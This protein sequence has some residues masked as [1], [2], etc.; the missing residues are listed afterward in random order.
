[1]DLKYVIAKDKEKKRAEMSLYGAIGSEING[2]YFAQS[3]D[4][5]SKEYDEI[6]IHI[7]SEGGSVMQ[8]LSI[9][10]AIL[11]SSA[12]I[13]AHIDGVAASMAG[14]IPMA[15]DKVVM[16]DFA[17][18]MIH[19][20]FFVGNN[21]LS[22]KEK[23]MLDNFTD[24]LADLL[25]RRG[26]EKEKMTEF[27]AKETWLKANEALELKLID[28]IVKTGKSPK[29]Q[30]SIAAIAALATEISPLNKIK[31][32][33]LIASLFG[34]SATATEAEIIAKVKALQSERDRLQAK[35][36]EVQKL[37]DDLKKE[38]EDKVKTDVN[39][40]VDKAIASGHFAKEQKEAL[41]E[42]GLKSFETFKTMVD[43][44]QP[45]K[46]SL[47]TEIQAQ[48][49]S[50]TGSQL[51]GEVKDFLWYSQNDPQ[52]LIEMKAS[53]PDKYRKLEKEYQEKYC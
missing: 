39:A 29:I 12:K 17:R 48:G 7:N 16:N 10:N 47:S 14:V 3:I 22:A 27:M 23:R 41:V 6:T 11:N 51:A 30:D 28:E 8:G 31:N 13:I 33:E 2:H 52:S 53:E 43:G 4:Y 46:S 37:A 26:I 32:M 44:L 45:I 15:A 49:G 42:M 20:P 35:V 5:L 19:N 34:L 18:I 25:S 38:K 24:L 1:M 40:L 9:F 36:D 50:V 21:K